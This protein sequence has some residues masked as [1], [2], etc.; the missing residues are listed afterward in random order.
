MATL[1]RLPRSCLLYMVKPITRDSPERNNHLKIYGISQ[2]LSKQVKVYTL[3][4]ELFEP[5]ISYIHAK[6]CLTGQIASFSVLRRSNQHP[7]NTSGYPKNCSRRRQA[8]FVCF[9]WLRFSE[10]YVKRRRIPAMISGCSFLELWLDF[11]EEGREL[12]FPR[13]GYPL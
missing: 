8:G 2:P 10:T 1:T 13:V 7:L 4:V 11:L 5:S 9:G 12:D 3:T 6:V